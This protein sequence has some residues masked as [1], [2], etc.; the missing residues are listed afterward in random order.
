MST[1]NRFH[2]AVRATLF[3]LA[4]LS[5]GACNSTAP[6]PPAT[7]AAPVSSAAS[8]TPSS[9]RLPEGAGCS[10]DVARFRAVIDN[11]L[12]TGHTTKSVHEKMAAEVNQAAAA[13]QTGQD[14]PARS[15]IAATKKRFGY[16]G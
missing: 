8:I 5:F 10:G 12:A 16:P 14:G 4:G 15:M 9:F 6:Q 2:P 1:I 11:D 13:C 7:A 3:S